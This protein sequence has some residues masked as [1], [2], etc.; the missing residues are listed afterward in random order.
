MNINDQAMSK[1][2]KVDNVFGIKSMFAESMFNSLSTMIK[3]RYGKVIYIDNNYYS[4]AIEWIKKYDHKFD[5]RPK[6]NLVKL[7]NIKYIIQ[8]EEGT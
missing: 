1:F 4:G 6:D 2:S 5:I 3:A 8:L 7:K